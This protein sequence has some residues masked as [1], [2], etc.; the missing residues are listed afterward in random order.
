MGNA[1]VN[2]SIFARSHL[3]SEWKTKSLQAQQNSITLVSV[4]VV[5]KLSFSPTRHQEN[6]FQD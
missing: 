3:G 4:L 2:L 6:S 1:P 5:Q